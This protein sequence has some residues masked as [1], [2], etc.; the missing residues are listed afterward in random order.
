MLRAERAEND[1]SGLY[2]RTCYRYKKDKY[3]ML[4]IND[5]QANVVRNTFN[6]YLEGHSIGGII[7]RLETNG[8]KSPKGKYRWSKKGIESK[9]TRRK[10]TRD[11]AIADSEGS[12]N[13]YLNKDHHDVIISKEQ[14]EAV[15]LEMELRSNVEIGED[16]I[17]CKKE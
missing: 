6:W 8:T 15:K 16:R 3:S 1:T 2:N 14:F 17:V 10:H 13:Q 9:L 7:N 12:E 4:V 5:K 11:V